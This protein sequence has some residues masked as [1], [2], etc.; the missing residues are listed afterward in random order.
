MIALIHNT[1]GAFT[2]CWAMIFDSVYQAQL[3]IRV[4]G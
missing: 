4:T 3:H 2:K 1:D